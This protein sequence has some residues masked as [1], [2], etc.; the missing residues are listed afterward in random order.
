M[1]SQSG[2]SSMA[3]EWDI[4]FCLFLLDFFRFLCFPVGR[5]KAAPLTVR[6]PTTAVKHHLNTDENVLGRSFPQSFP[7]IMLRQM[8]DRNRREEIWEIKKHRKRKKTMNKIYFSLK[9]KESLRINNL[10]GSGLM[11]ASSTKKLLKVKRASIKR[12]IEF[13][14]SAIEFAPQPRRQR[15]L[16]QFFAVTNFC[17][18]VLLVRKTK[19][20]GSNSFRR[21]NTAQLIDDDL[22]MCPHEHEYLMS[23]AEFFRKK[24]DNENKEKASDKNHNLYSHRVCW[25]I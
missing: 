9:I 1:S 17:L 2:A 18:K 7:I 13:N 21:F 10:L 23:R 16:D 6:R 11:V 8:V 22:Y 14:S 5:L 3:C 12:S 24:G 19:D 20:E 4:C 25:F 15:S